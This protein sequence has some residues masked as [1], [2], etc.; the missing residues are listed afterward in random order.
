M[1]V[2]G[3]SEEGFRVRLLR[4]SMLRR[5]ALQV[6]IK[7]LLLYLIVVMTDEERRVELQGVARDFFILERCIHGRLSKA[8]E[9]SLA[10]AV[11]TF[12]E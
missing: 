12:L 3:L 4:E 1:V 6:C 5:G 8:R 2:S 11:W 10:C 9:T 7:L